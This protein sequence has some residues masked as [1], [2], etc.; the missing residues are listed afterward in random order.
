MLYNFAE[1]A[2]VPDDI[3]CLQCHLL[4]FFLLG[5][6]IMYLISTKKKS[7]YGLIQAVEAHANENISNCPPI[8]H[9]FFPSMHCVFP[10]LGNILVLTISPKDL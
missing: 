4:V 8:D 10:T 2:F 3:I 7:S 1:L 9:T 6:V 5:R